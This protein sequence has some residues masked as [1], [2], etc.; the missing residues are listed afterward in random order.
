MSAAETLRQAAALIRS[1]AKA[2]TPGPWRFTDSEAVNDVWAGGMVVVSD[3]AD[4]IA[5]VQ[6][7][8]YEN[9]PGEPAPVNDAEHIASWNPVVA[10]AVADLLDAVA[11]VADHYPPLQI[12]P[13]S[14]ASRALVLAR[15]YLG[16]QS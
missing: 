9:D 7:E 6:D 4:P 3:D 11:L 16:V 10:L 12:R 5:N 2:A 14:A 15:A 13:D 8:W 1:R